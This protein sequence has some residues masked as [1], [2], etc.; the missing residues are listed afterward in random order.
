[1]SLEDRGVSVVDKKRRRR[2]ISCAGSTRLKLSTAGHVL[3]FRPHPALRLFLPST[4][5]V[6]ALMVLV[7]SYEVELLVSR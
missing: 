2:G 5:V 4:M 3:L 6:R 7:D 1:M